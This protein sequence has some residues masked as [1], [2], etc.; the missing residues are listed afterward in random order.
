MKRGSFLKVH[1]VVDEMLLVGAVWHD[2]RIEYHMRLPT[3]K[4]DSES[5]GEEFDIAYG[6]SS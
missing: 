4:L 5:Q 6:D 3:H 2:M 1:N